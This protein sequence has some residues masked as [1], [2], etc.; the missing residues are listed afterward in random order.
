MRIDVLLM[1]AALVTLL[2]VRQ[3]TS[4]PVSKERHSVKIFSNLA[5][6][7][8]AVGRPRPGRK[9]LLL[10]VYV[11][12]APE[13]PRRLPALL[14]LH[15]GGFRRGDKNGAIAQ[16]ARAVAARGLVAV[17]IDYR[18]V[19]DSPPGDQSDEVRRTLFAAREDAAKALEWMRRNAGKYR[20]DEDRIA[21]GGSSAGAIA[22]LFLAYA[23]PGPSPV[24][25]TVDL[26]G[27]MYGEQEMIQPGD[28]PLLIVHGSNDYTV[29]FRLAVDLKSRCLEVGV[30]FEFHPVAGSGHGFAAIPPDFIV[31][32]RDLATVV[33]DFLKERLNPKR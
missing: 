25:A 26:W 18:L 12:D 28:P 13:L 11:P 23:K 21:V 9:E 10:D 14:L 19:P 8:G 6:G 3:Q 4:P 20:I 7:W 15:G 16:L 31:D 24:R 29:P 30:P 33:A 5:Y 17:A 32:G 2:V 27:G 22:G 1:A